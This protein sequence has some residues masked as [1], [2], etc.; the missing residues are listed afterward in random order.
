M[1]YFIVLDS[2]LVEESKDLFVEKYSLLRTSFETAYPQ[3]GFPLFETLLDREK[4][5][6][7][8]IYNEEG[9]K[10]DIESFVEK[11]E[12]YNLKQ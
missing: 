3:E 6:K 11:L 12:D 7:F 9:E 1:E 8:E 5:D 2:D 4:T 10:F